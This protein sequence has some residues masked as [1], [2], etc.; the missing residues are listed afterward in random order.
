PP[1]PPFPT[2][3]TF[4]DNGGPTVLGVQSVQ[5]VRIAPAPA[6]DFLVDNF[7][8]AAAPQPAIAR[9]TLP[10]GMQALA[11][12]NKPATSS[13]GATVNYNRPQFATE[14]VNGGYQI[15]LRA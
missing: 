9:F 7:T 5:L 12:L 3:V 15:S 6:L 8:Q 4:A 11:N 2:P 10:F 14:S 13:R 1:S